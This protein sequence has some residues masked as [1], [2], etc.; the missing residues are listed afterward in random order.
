MP[1]TTVSGGGSNQQRL[2]FHGERVFRDVL[3]SLTFKPLMA[4]DDEGSSFVKYRQPELSADSLVKSNHGQGTGAYD[5]FYIT[6]ALTDDPVKNGA[7]DLLVGQEESLV[8]RVFNHEIDMYEKEVHAG[9]ILSHLRSF[10]D[11]KGSARMG[12]TNLILEWNDKLFFNALNADST[13][14]DFVYMDTNGAVT[15]T[16]SDPTGSVGTTKINPEML[17]ELSEIA[18]TADSVNGNLSNFR[19]KK[20]DVNGKKCFIL[21]VPPRV[22]T[23]LKIDPTF[24]QYRREVSA[25]P[26]DQLFANAVAVI[27]DIIVVESEHVS[28]DSAN[29]IARCSLIGESSLCA[30]M[31]RVG[32]VGVDIQEYDKNAKREDLL[33]ARWFLKVS[34]PQFANAAG[35]TKDFGSL[36]VY[37]AY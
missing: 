5:R 25:M 16:T 17:V 30:T 36:G 11:L 31:A 21:L 15:S 2:K 37:L 20:V 27:E 14:T 24:A 9:T 7:R 32:G 23:Q 33:V 29:S 6:L 28:L 13:P 12:L 1:K 10:I 22:G 18:R 8:N 34:K 19:M 3:A 35:A 4:G 26:S